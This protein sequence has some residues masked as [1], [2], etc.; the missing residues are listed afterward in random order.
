MRRR[1]KLTELRFDRWADDLK[2]WISD[3]VSPFDND[4]PEKQAA[5]I[6]R[7]EHDLLYFCKTYLP[8]YFPADFGEFHE[9]WEDLSE[10]RD[11]CVFCAAPREHAKSTFFS[12][13]IPVRNICFKK[14]WFQLL[15]SDTNDQATGF[16]LPIRLELEE[17]PR[18]KHDF[19][20]LRGGTWKANDFTTVN[21]VRT[22][23]RGRGEKVRGLKNRQ[24]R[25]DFAVVDD[26]EN[27]VNVE[28]PTLVNKGIK[29]LKRAVIGSMGAGYTFLMIGNLFH[30]KSVL[31][32]FIAEKDEDGSKLYVSR[33]YRAWIK[34]GKPDQHP[35]WSAAWPPE[36]LEKKRRQMGS[37]DFNAEMMNLTGAENSPFPEKW[38]VFYEPETLPEPLSMATFTDPSAKSGEA[39]DYKATITVGLDRKKMIFYVMHSW[40]R[41]ASPGEMFRESYHRFDEYGGQVGIEENMLKD[42][43]HEAIQNYAKEVGRYLPWRAMHHSTN[44]EARI[45]GTL[46]YLV[47]YGKLR[48]QKGQS[49]QDLLVEQ[50]IYLLN[51]NV[52]DDGPDALEGAV[53]ML[54]GGLIA[55]GGSDPEGSGRLAREAIAGGRQRPGTMEEDREQPGMFR[56][57]LGGQQLMRRTIGRG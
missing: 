43:L 39:N 22:L 28:N 40:I 41:H 20:N 31:S 54:Q 15:I 19:G 53:T 12:F 27:D 46:S 7:A 34:Y 14:R 32:Q 11:E 42:F 10:I 6:A 26:F 48:F 33:V 56:R 18:L 44:K 2:Q 16:S 51:K 21:G 4:T 9:E 38:F 8:H 23:A 25:P 50:L 30:P 29:W 13:A 17:N 1:P 52:N 37:V 24:H 45:I 5:R 3:S 36:R 57:R 49:D 47:E 55:Y 35:L